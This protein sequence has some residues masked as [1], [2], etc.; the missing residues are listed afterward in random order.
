MMKADFYS[1]KILFAFGHFVLD[2]LTDCV[3]TLRLH[4]LRGL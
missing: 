3:F 1:V 4:A 2:L